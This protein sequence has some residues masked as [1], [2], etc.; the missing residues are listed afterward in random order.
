MDRFLKMKRSSRIIRDFKKQFLGRRVLAIFFL[1]FTSF[2][3]LWSVIKDYELKK[4][5]AR[6]LATETRSGKNWYWL[7][8]NSLDTTD[9]S[10]R[11]SLGLILQRSGFPPGTRLHIPMPD[12]NPDYLAKMGFLP[13]YGS[14][15]FYDF[16]QFAQFDNKGGIQS[17]VRDTTG[18]LNGTSIFSATPPETLNIVITPVAMR[19]PE[20][21]PF[22]RYFICGQ[23]ICPAYLLKENKKVFL[24]S[25]EDGEALTIENRMPG[26][27]IRQPKTK[28]LESKDS[29]N[30]LKNSFA[31]IVER[32]FYL[33][34][35]ASIL[36][37]FAIATSLYIGF[38]SPSK[39]LPVQIIGFIVSLWGIRT[40][41]IG[42]TRI[43]MSFLDYTLS[44]TYLVL[45]AGVI[46]R[47]IRGSLPGKV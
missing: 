44:F 22:D 41:I 36:I 35:M 24:D 13:Y 33:R 12:K 11:G 43:F 8:L 1:I 39:D 15:L 20:F 31:L 47:L 27:L 21:Y 14:L 40:I 9:K 18:F 3:F 29:F 25:L 26:V 42:D 17:F 4:S 2:L 34:F 32:P 23:I 19:S 37:I 6:H 7:R 5:Y 45:F 10:I 30:N 28:E 46:F 38:K 16:S